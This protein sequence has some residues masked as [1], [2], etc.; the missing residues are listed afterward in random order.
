[1]RRL[2]D[3]F[4]LL[5][6][7]SVNIYDQRNYYRPVLRPAINYRRYSNIEN[8]YPNHS[9][10]INGD[11]FEELDKLPDNSID[12]CFADPPYN[13]NKK[14]ESWNDGIDIQ[15]YFEWCDKWLSSLARVLK[16]GRTLAVL[17]I[18]QWCIRHF[19]HLITLMDYQDWIVWEGLSMPVRMIMP[20]HYS[21]LCF[22]KGKPRPL[23]GLARQYNS[24]LEKKAVETLSDNYCIRP[25][26]MKTRKRLQYKDTEIASNLWW[27]I[28]R[29]KHNS[30]RVDHPCQLPPNFM[31][32]LI[33]L[34]THEN[35][36]VL[37]PFNG[38]GTTTLTAKELNRRYIGIELSECYFNLASERH[39]ELEFGLDPFRKNGE[40]PKTKN[41]PV[42][43]LKKQKYQ[44]SKK[45]LQLEVKNIS[46]QLGRIPT[47]DEVA[48]LSKFPI[49]YFDEYFISWGEVTAA[50][51]TTGMSEFKKTDKAT[52]QLPEAQLSFIKERNKL[53]SRKSNKK[54]KIIALESI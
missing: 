45:V 51:R 3:L 10:L 4:G 37:D 53:Y 27:D 40:T 47:R 41:S 26:C 13:L 21:I 24:P 48:K 18:P 29:L 28:H 44:V 5:E 34:F 54:S 33:A 30:R 22:S 14:Y 31:Y 20:A 15:T 17:N 49:N 42:E 2:Q 50:A 35:E 16:P 19:R 36:I 32:R 23:P 52:Y 9:A 1:V 46:K 7:E 25:S 6:Y 11:C 8:Q 43:R 12:F 39:K 38:V